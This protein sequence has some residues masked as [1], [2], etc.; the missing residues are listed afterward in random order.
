M[1]TAVHS[2]SY[3]NR[4]REDESFGFHEFIND[5]AEKGFMSAEI[6]TGTPGKIQKDIGTDDPEE[7][8]KRQ[9][10][11][12]ERGVEIH[13]LSTY[14]DFAHLGND[15]WQRQ[16]DDLK[17]WICLA[18]ERQIPNIRLLTGYYT[19]ADRPAEQEQRTL[20]GIRACVEIAEQAGVNLA[21]ENHSTVFMSALEVV[22]VIEQIGSKRV[23]T[24]PDP[25]NQFPNFFESQG[26]F[27]SFVYA[28]AANM[29][30]YATNSHLKIKGI[31]DDGTLIGWDID[32]LLAIYKRA[33]YDG[34]ITFESVCEG[35]LIAPLTEA[36]RIVDAAIQRLENPSEL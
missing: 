10:Y 19:D 24:C 27:R 31:G 21:L 6:M 35:D 12:R 11:A 36:K 23:T 33:G 22:R 8:R 29:A 26:N 7:L 1:Y 14:N 13:C 15:A 9:A 34:P 18:G 20:D 4:F 28:G 5:V 25:S 3:R 30:K 32:R 17:K 2:Y 16:V